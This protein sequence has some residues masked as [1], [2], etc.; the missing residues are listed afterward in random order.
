MLGPAHLHILA[1]NFAAY[2][3]R[4]NIHSIPAFPGNCDI[5]SEPHQSGKDR[6]CREFA[7]DNRVLGLG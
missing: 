5:T 6:G 4:V 3:V 2:L 1:F 7:S